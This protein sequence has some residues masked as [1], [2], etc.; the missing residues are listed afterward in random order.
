MFWLVSAV[1]S[2]EFKQQ[3]GKFWLDIRK[4]FPMI[5][6]MKREDRVPGERVSLSYWSL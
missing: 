6:L 1:G 3:Q 2:H 5:R 4:N